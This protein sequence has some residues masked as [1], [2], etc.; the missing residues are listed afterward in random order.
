MRARLGM[1]WDSHD[2]V[3]LLTHMTLDWEDRPFGPIAAIR[4]GF[5]RTEF[6][7]AAERGLIG[8]GRTESDHYA[9]EG[10]EIRAHNTEHPEMFVGRHRHGVGRGIPG[11]CVG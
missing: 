1:E 10:R 2:S 8:E 9:E 5:A 4:V 7:L 6:V 3:S 11:L